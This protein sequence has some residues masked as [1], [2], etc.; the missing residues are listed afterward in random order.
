M[1]T[2]ISVLSCQ[3]L[4]VGKRHGFAH[5]LILDALGEGIPQPVFDERYGQMS[6]V[7]ADPTALEAL[8]DSDRGSGPAERIEHQLLLVAAGLDDAFQK[9]LGLLRR[10]A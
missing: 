5:H 8:R 10:I 7:N 6:D 1:R 2:P 4:G 3:R 9:C